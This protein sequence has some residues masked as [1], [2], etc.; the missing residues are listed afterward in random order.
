MRDQVGM[1]TMKTLLEQLQQTVKRGNEGDS[2]G[3]EGK[4]VKELKMS[5]RYNEEDADVTIISSDGV[6][7][8]V[9]SFLL[10]RAS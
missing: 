1:N 4:E 7:F 2:K 10:L 3:E 9:Y 6:V 5:E 8:K